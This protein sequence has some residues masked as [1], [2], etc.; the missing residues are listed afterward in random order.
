MTTHHQK[1]ELLRLAR[2]GHIRRLEQLLNCNV[3]VNFLHHKTGMTPLMTAAYAGQAA[4]VELLL[5]HN[6]DPNLRSTDNASALHWACLFGDVRI[7]E[8]LIAAGSDLNVRRENNRHE[9]GPTPLHMAI[10]KSRDDIAIALIDA[11]ASVDIDYFGLTVVEYA[12]RHGCQLVVAHL[13]Q[14][15]VRR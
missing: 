5:K 14:L 8:M 9:G 2:S 12:E 1:R 4:A 6:A 10:G 15:G 11:G 13:Q 7:V 3:D